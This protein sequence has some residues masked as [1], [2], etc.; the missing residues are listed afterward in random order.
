MIFPTKEKIGGD[1]SFIKK[2][3]QALK[4]KRNRGVK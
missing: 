3:M 1:L 2:K 4:L